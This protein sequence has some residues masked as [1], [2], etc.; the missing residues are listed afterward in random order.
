MPK[1]KPK[2][3]SRRPCLAE[4]PYDISEGVTFSMLSD[5]CSCMESCRLSLMGWRRQGRSDALEYGTFWHNMLETLGQGIIAGTY[6]R[7]ADALTIVDEE[8]AR[9][10]QRVVA[11][12][13]TTPEEDARTGLT[14]AK[15]QALWPYYLE[16]F[17]KDFRKSLWLA[18][19]G[20][21]DVMFEG[22]RLR[23]MCDG[24]R[25]EKRSVLWLFETKTRSQISDDQ[26]TDLLEFDPQCLM[27]VIAN[28][29]ALKRKIEHV[30]YNVIRN[31]SQKLTTKGGTKTLAEYKAFVAVDCEKR[32]DHYFKR[33]ENTFAPGAIEKYKVELKNK[34]DAFAM[35]LRGE[36]PHFKNDGNNGACIGRK[37]NCSYISAC[38]HPENMD[39]NYEQTGRL[40]VELEG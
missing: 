33:Y 28:G 16:V 20:Q 37:F 18:V 15:A 14:I 13:W 35:W 27:Y 38:A 7:P 10:K 40:M 9:Y 23:G 25:R 24:V 12:G 2:P 8:A 22:Y 29:I 6:K 11:S 31:P 32:P 34:L 1:A 19:E 3:Q 26:I 4:K 30:R 5:W 21:F 39:L 36:L 17:A